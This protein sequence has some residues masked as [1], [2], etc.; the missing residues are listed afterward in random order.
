MHIFFDKYK[1]FLNKNNEIWE[2]FRNITKKKLNS[3]LS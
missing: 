1:E 2:M 3:E